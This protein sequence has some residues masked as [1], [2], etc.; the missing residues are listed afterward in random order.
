MSEKSFPGPIEIPLAVAKEWEKRYED[1]TTIED[2]KNKVKSFLIPRE[3]LEKVLQLEADAIR[4][5]IGINDQKERT[6]LFVGA[7]F[8][9]ETGEYTDVYGHSSSSQQSKAADDDIVYDGARP[10]PPY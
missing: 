3:S 2:N 10:S 9:K 6:L 1:D 8:D 4:A 5:Y 7:K